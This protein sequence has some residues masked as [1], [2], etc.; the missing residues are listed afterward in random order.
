M[1]RPK[2]FVTLKN[3]FLPD[4]CEA[5]AKKSQIFSLPLHTNQVKRIFPDQEKSGMIHKSGAKRFI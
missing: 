3:P 1:S 5:E 2:L 4:L